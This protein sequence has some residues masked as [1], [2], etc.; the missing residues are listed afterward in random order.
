MKKILILL[1]CI[2]SLFSYDVLVVKAKILSKIAHELVKK[3]IVNIYV[4]DKDLEKTKGLVPSL[5]YT[6][7]DEADIVFISEIDNIAK[8]KK[9]IFSTSYYVYQKNSNVLGAFFW[10]KGRPNIIIK[11]KKA[12]SLNISFSPSFQKYVE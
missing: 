11:S 9:Y 8:N 3:D 1:L 2:S 4:E 10:Q 12:E 7:Y 5:K 6:S